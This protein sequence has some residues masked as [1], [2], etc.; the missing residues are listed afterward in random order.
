MQIDER[1]KRVQFAQQ[2]QSVKKIQPEQDKIGK[3]GTAESSFYSNVV[4]QGDG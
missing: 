3:E 4:P 2:A 1:K